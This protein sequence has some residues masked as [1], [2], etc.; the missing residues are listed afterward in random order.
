[1]SPQLAFEQNVMLYWD[2]ASMANGSHG[3]TTLQVVTSRQLGN[4]RWR[5]FPK[6]KHNR[7][8]HFLMTEEFFVNTP[9]YHEHIQDAIGVDEEAKQHIVALA[10]RSHDFG[11]RVEECEME[12]RHRLSG[13]LALPRVERLMARN[14]NEMETKY[15][16]FVQ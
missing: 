1:M 13:T 11:H 9:K 2:E 4:Q 14:H 12:L 6:R 5:L 3:E 8:P 7:L 15:N 16:N 10:Q